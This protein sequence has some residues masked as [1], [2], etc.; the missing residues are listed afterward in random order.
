VHEHY[1]QRGKGGTLD[2]LQHKL[3]TG[4]RKLAISY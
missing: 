4:L 3:R 1:T 2:E